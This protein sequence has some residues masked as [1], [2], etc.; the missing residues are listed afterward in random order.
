MNNS[1][2]MTDKQAQ[3]NNTLPWDNYAEILS[4]LDWQQLQL[5]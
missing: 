4:D 5:R 1:D 2:V 3:G